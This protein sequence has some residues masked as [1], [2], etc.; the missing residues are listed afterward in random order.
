MP[1]TV[2]KHEKPAAK[3]A[4]AMPDRGGERGILFGGPLERRRS[5]GNL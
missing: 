5:A 2:E 1:C 3:A 4:Q